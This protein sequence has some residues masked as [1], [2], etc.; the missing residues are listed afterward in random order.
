M[1]KLIFDLSTLLIGAEGTKIPEN[2]FAFFF[3]RCLFRE[4]YSNSCGRNL[5]PSGKL[6]AGPEINRPY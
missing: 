2:A 5:G 6:V 4:A 1:L 3:V